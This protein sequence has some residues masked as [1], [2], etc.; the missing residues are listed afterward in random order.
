MVITLFILHQTLSTTRELATEVAAVHL[1]ELV[2]NAANTRQLAVISADID[3]LTRTYHLEG[4]NLTHEGERIIENLS[5]ITAGMK[6]ATLRGQLEI[7]EKSFKRFLT[8][9]I[10]VNT[11]LS[12]LEQVARTAQ[13]ELSSLE[14]LISNWMIESTLAGVDTDYHDQLLSLLTG[15]KE[16]LLIID[17]RTAELAIH[18]LSVDIESDSLLHELDTLY[19]RLQ[20]ISATTPEVVVHGRQLTALIDSYRSLTRLL[21]QELVGLSR[22]WRLLAL[23]ESSIHL[24]IEQAE[25][26]ASLAADHV[27][28]EINKLIEDTGTHMSL[29]L[30]IIIM[31]IMGAMFYLLRRHI[32]KPLNALINAVSTMRIEQMDQPIRLGRKDEWRMIE[33]AL[34]DMNRKLAYSYAE[35]EQSRASF[36]ALVNNVPG[37]VY[38]C[39][40]DSDW[41]M[42]YLSDG[43]VELTG[44]NTDAVISNNE[45]SYAEIIHPD[46]RVVVESAVNEAVERGLPFTIEYRIVRQDGG[47][48][49]LF[50]Q[51]QATTNTNH[52]IEKKLDGVI[53]DVTRQ[54]QLSDA[55]AESETRYRLLLEHTTEGIFGFDV[56]GITTFINHAASEMLG[57][58]PDEMIGSKNHFLIHHSLHDGTPL[59]EGDCCMMKP[60][61]DGVDYHV[62]DEVLWHKN[63]ECFPIE[64]WSAP[65][66]GDDGIIGAV[67]SF[68][69]I[70]ERK[71]SEENMQHLA[72]HD[73]LTGLPNRS[74]F[75]M[76]LKQVIAQFRRYGERFALHLMD[77]DHFKEVNDRLGHPLGD[78]LLQQV[79]K[80]LMYTI[81]ETD[82]L[83]RLGG[84]EFAL[85]QK[86]LDSVSDAS[87]L[88][89]K[90][91]D[92]FSED[93]LI[94]DNTIYINTS[95]GIFIPDERKIKLEEILSNA[96]VALYK[97]KE[98]G[99]GV[100]TFFGDEMSLQ[101]HREMNLSHD[102]TLALKRE[103]FFLQYQ[104][105]FDV[106]SGE[107]VGIE[108][109]VRWHH[110]S[111]GVMMPV[112]FIHIAEKRG[113]I[114]QISDWVMHEACLQAKAWSEKQIEFGCIAINLCAKQ[115]NDTMFR[116]NIEEILAT[117]GIAPGLLEFE[118]TETVLVEATDSTRES[119]CYLSD[120]GI[121]FA[122]DDFGTGFSS[123]SYLRQFNAEK[124]KIDREFIRD[125]TN[126]RNDAEIVK[127]AIALGK[128]LNLTVVA[129][130]VETQSQVDFLNQ[131]HCDILQ[132]FL[133][134]H[135][136][137]AEELEQRFFEPDDSGDMEKTILQET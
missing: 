78:R 119:I 9:S 2:D 130:G 70:T 19:L 77:L 47:V 103:E 116:Q 86:N 59:P 61:K 26:E 110:P 32:E 37:I 113:I 72:Y 122:I 4:G 51:G 13:D 53:L 54:K 55:L 3:R 28:D 38:R 129:E 35:L 114:K 29:F 87:Y 76:E 16:S 108:A 100:F 109:L 58:T 36:R 107:I 106:S 91:I 43:F 1:N 81:R 71:R 62:E 118:F 64:Y 44:Y 79:A 80:R 22:D 101:M 15:Y 56:N 57:Y 39:K 5:V 21:L 46:D 102:L 7:Y 23:Y 41:T 52:Q 11:I 137:S 63:G 90:V 40:L 67:V 105:Q 48:R 45:I 20:T 89:S 124:I 117:S 136:L 10:S 132:G 125:V 84:D 25:S 131:H 127:A 128:S 93:F 115:I 126:S 85:I 49:W 42:E 27:R 68:H 98:A 82:V 75:I 74:L 97:A 14:L 73:M 66:K 94:E 121:H 95:V 99:R 83:A 120:L 12:N 92:I 34:N 112:D 69:D 135:P 104:P 134:S 31:I 50:E 123:L 30:M 33:K 88:A 111:H 96:D 17:K 60:I 65:I 133:Y 24:M 6:D 18:N 8:G